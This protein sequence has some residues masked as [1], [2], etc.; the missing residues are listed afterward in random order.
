MDEMEGMAPKESSTES[1]STQ[2]QGKTEKK[3]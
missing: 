2:Y 3:F 1:D